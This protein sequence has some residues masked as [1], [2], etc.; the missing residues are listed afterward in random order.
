MHFTHATP[1]ESINSMSRTL[2]TLKIFDVSI[3]S[4]RPPRN[5]ERFNKSIDSFLRYTRGSSR[6]TDKGRDALRTLIE[7]V[8]T[9]RALAE[10]I[11]SFGG[12]SR[13]CR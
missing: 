5:I 8:E 9:S 2:D 11:Y 1:D 6:L 10:S 3:I 4:G 7:R 12:S 13:E